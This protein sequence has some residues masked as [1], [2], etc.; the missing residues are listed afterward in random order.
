MIHQKKWFVIL[1]LFL[2]NSSIAQNTIPHLQEA[3]LNS[4]NDSSK[5][6]LY[7]K[8]G[9]LQEEVNLDTAIAT[10]QKA[11][12]LSIKYKDTLS[13]S[14]SYSN[15]GIANY[16]KSNYDESIKYYQLAIEVYQYLDNQQGVANCYDNIGTVYSDQGNYN[17][18]IEYYLK[19][20]KIYEKI[21]SQEGMSASYNNI[22][23]LYYNL[24]EY[25][26]ALSYYSQAYNI[27][28]LNNNKDGMANYFNNIG[29]IYY[30][31][32]E[33]DKALQYYQK[34]LDLEKELTNKSGIALS[35]SNI[36]LAQNQKGLLNES[37]TNYKNALIYY[38]KVG[39]KH[40]ITSCYI[41]IASLKE[42]FSKQKSIS[43][44]KQK[45]YLN[46]ATEYAL[47][48]LE[49][50]ES[51]NSLPRKKDALGQLKECYYLRGNYKESI[52]YAMLYNTVKDSLFNIEK[53][54]SLVKLE[55]KYQYNKKLAIDSI[56]NAKKLQIQK[57]ELDKIKAENK[58][59]TAQNYLFLLGI[60][61]SLLVSGL[62]FW[63]YRQK[64]K[65]NTLLTEQKNE[66][67]EQ[68]D[69][70]N[71]LIEEVTSQRDLVNLQKDQMAIILKAVS[72]SIDYA[73]KIQNATLPKPVYLKTKFN[74]FFILFKPRD[75]VSGDFYW[76]AEVENEIVIAVADC[77]GHGV[78]GAIMSMLGM[79]LLKET[80]VK[81]YITHPGV[82]LRRLR[83]EII[84]TLQQTG[85]IGEQKDGMDMAL[86]SISYQ[87]KILQF[88]GANNPLYIITQTPLEHYEAQLNLCEDQTLLFYEI[89]ADNMPI[90]IYNK[91]GRYTTHEIPIRK[92]D[93]LYMFSDGLADQFGGPKGKKFMRKNFKKTLLKNAHLPMQEQKVILEE[94]FGNW[95]GKEEQV[96]D[97]VVMG[98]K[99]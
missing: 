58:R 63:N 25:N 30:N 28:S 40:G 45:E 46:E 61:L 26:K 62:I 4:K 92:G 54:Q 77:T 22:G 69:K 78:P 52:K 2:F 83:K 9:I 66:I 1:L 17:K 39:N 20:I 72:Q 48:A 29:T 82:I 91:M 57:L 14:R 27:D 33:Y 64:Q 60:L 8:L 24:N 70:L 5:I 85:E 18:A 44:K 19:D 50:A 49:L 37:F 80:V 41:H 12:N 79:S 99:I 35:Y 96:D 86:I 90:S 23:A 53:H 36:G 7:I 56:A 95:K 76:W 3:I 16:F 73:K 67:S 94:T 87:N 74:D 65:A 47:Q 71:H 55:S 42:T 88:A 38:Q 59:R 11:V 10:Y 21:G 68:N 51:I 13:L 97:I 6:V 81:E 32:Q 43:K 31:Q 89:K 34:S 75:I 15:L 84:N 93:Q 98:I